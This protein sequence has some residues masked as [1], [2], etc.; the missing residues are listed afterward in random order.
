M[1]ECD[2]VCGL[3]VAH[4]NPERA[5]I[6]A[7]LR[8]NLCL[9]D[10][11]EFCLRSPIL[12]LS[13]S[14]LIFNFPFPAFSPALCQKKKSLPSIVSIRTKFLSLN[15]MVAWVSGRPSQQQSCGFGCFRKTEGKKGGRNV[16]EEVV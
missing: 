5:A 8:L 10:G 6:A 12:S 1:L 11:S 4:E 7:C 9:S 13:F 16:G 2:R 14:R 15:K 3:G